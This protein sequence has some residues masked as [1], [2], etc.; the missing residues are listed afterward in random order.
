VWEFQAEGALVGRY[1]DY[2]ARLGVPWV[3]VVTLA[4]AH[5]RNF[6]DTWWAGLA[7]LAATD[8]YQS[9][10]EAMRQRIEAKADQLTPAPIAARLR[11]AGYSER[12]LD[13]IRGAIEV[14]SHGNFA[15][16][17]AVFLARLALEGHVPDGSGEKPITPP[18]HSGPPPDA[19]SFVLVEPH[20]ALS[21]QQAIYDDIKATIGLPFVNTDYRYLARWPSYFAAAWSDLKPHISTATYEDLAQAAHD[22][23]VATP[24]S[25]PN[26]GGLNA[27]LLQAAAAQDGDLAE[28]RAVTELFTWLL[29]G[30]MLNVAYF[31]RQLID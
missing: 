30:L 6:Y 14:L 22:D 21:D 10:A 4:Y 29:P 20:H 8:A 15:Q 16:M 18:T 2:K 24:L 5:Y 23:M 31:R 19:P 3:G 9:A 25:L 1:E 26:I 28:C 13:E 11:S 17:P 12:E 27:E 7:P